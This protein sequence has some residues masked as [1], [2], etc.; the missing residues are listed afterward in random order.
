MKLRTGQTS[1][2]VTIDDVTI[3]GRNISPTEV[4]KF[5]DKYTVGG[6]RGKESRTDINKVAFD[7]FDARLQSWSGEIV[8]MENQPLECNRASK[9][10]IWEYDQQFCA[11]ILEALDE[12][13]ELREDIAEKN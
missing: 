2:N 11:Q 8:D 1:V 9:K 4:K 12:A 7:I 5:T 10:L 3:T 6:S 13:F